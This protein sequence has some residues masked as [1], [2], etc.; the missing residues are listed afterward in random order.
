MTGKRIGL[1]VSGASSG[2]S[3][4]E[5]DARRLIPDGNFLTPSLWSRSSQTSGCHAMIAE[6]LKIS[7]IRNN[8]FR[9]FA[10]IFVFYPYICRDKKIGRGFVVFDLRG[11]SG[12]DI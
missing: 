7:A 9:R 11:G 5:S 8:I 2:I 12:R 10:L 6:W 4:V 3:G 1:I